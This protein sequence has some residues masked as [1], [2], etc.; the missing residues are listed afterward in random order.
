MTASHTSDRPRGPLD[1]LKVL[2]V[3]TI[4]AGPLCAQ[5]LGDFG[6]DVIKIEHPVAG[7]S[8]RT[9]GPS[10]DGHGLWWRIVSRNKRCIGLYLGD[11][12]GAEV[13]RSLVSVADVLVENF[14][15]GT[16]ERWGLGWDE[17]HELNPRLVMVRITGFG[18]DG[19][20]RSR[21]GFGTL[22]EAMSGFAAIT[23]QADG[24][25]T[26][27][28]MGLADSIAGISGVAAIMMALWHR[29]RPGGSGEGQMIDLSLLEPIMCAV[30]P[31]PT[32]Y[33]QLG[34]LQPRV[35]NRSTSNAPR[36][37]YLTRDGRWLA[38]ST[39]ATTIA[40]QVMRLV[41]HPEVTDEPWFAS[42]KGRAEHVDLL[43][44]YVA[45]WIIERDAAEVIAA[46]EEAE[47]AVAP[48]YTAA[49]ILEDPQVQA[50]EMI[51]TVDDPDL[52]PLRMNNVLFRMSDTPGR[53]RFPGRSEVGAD[54]DEVLAEV[55]V[56]PDVIRSLRDRKVIR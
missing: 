54:T 47:A 29:D 45:E 40:E 3:S 18:Q 24:P 23:G 21:A 15:P 6:A 19:P 37:T 43:D 5:V 28:S 36:N 2:D 44:S 35:G 46:F 8:F 11:P 27:P 39:S 31:G 32:V 20:Y 51:T 1:G 52:G 49:D 26:L 48:V 7:D 17:L 12:D 14:R 25:P 30:G 41:G 53:I 55:G 38:I 16:L 34:T 13:F 33:D 9:H 4:L 56:D 50:L 10:K 42:A 22:A